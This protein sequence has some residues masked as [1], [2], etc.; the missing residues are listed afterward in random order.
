MES[1]DDLGLLR[2]PC[3]ITIKAMGL[4]DD[5]FEPL[6]VGL[7]RAHAPDLGEN[8]VSTRASS[9]GK[10]LAVSV[11]VQAQSRRQMDAIYRDL[12]AHHKVLMAL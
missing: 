3:E 2:F 10:Y 12:S 4:A 7:V 1:T 9:G 5:G 8:A 11:A 6:V